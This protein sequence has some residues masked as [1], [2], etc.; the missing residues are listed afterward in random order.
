MADN[1]WEF[2]G[3][4]LHNNQLYT[5]RNVVLRYCVRNSNTVIAGQPQTLIN[6]VSRINY[7]LRIIHLH[8]NFQRHR[9]LQSAHDN[10]N[11]LFGIHV[12]KDLFSPGYS[13]V[14]KTDSIKVKEK[15]FGVQLS[16]FAGI[17]ATKSKTHLT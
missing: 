2:L 12:N 8:S 10:Y 17:Y 1:H 4:Y 16:F 9:S 7:C 13:Q 6:I 5:F 11:E 14:H 3:D 15:K